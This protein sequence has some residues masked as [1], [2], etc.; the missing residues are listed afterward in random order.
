M[1]R[2]NLLGG[3]REQDEDI[4]DTA[5]REVSEETNG[6]LTAAEARALLSSAIGP[7]AMPGRYRTHFVFLPWA[8]YHNL[9]ER[10]RQRGEKRPSTAED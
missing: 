8:R 10:Y 7:L 1:L 6:L 9:P 3:K 2:L 4:I 5:S